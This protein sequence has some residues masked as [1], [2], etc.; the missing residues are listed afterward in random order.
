MLFL[1]GHAWRTGGHREGGAIPAPD[2]EANADHEDDPVATAA[3][4]LHEYPPLALAAVQWRDLQG[5]LRLVV[6]DE[7]LDAES[8]RPRI[9]SVIAGACGHEDFD[10]LSGTLTETASRAA[11][12]LDA[13]A[14]Q[15]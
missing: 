2:E 15:A 7:E 9:K 1:G 14:A 6:G 11:E 8:A 13:L 5:V 4:V 12:E 3:A 10:A